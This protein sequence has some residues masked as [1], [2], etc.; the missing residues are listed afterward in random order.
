MR[1]NVK[2][3]L[4]G[5]AALTAVMAAAQ[6]GSAKESPAEIKI[7]TF[8]G[9]YLAGRV[10]ESDNDLDSAI[11]YYKQALGFDPTDQSLQQSLM[12]AL[13]ARGRFDES[14]PYAEQLKQVPEVER[15]SRLAL[16]VDTMRKGNFK[17]TEEWLKL[18]LES[19]LDRLITKLMSAW[20]KLGD[21]DAAG[22]LKAL[23]DLRGPQWY[24]TFVGYHTAL[25]AEAAGDKQKA[26]KA[27]SETMNDVA[28]GSAAPDAYLRSAEAYT[29]F[30]MRDGR[31]NEALAILDRADQFAANR[32]QLKILRDKINKGEPIAPTV[33]T[34][35]D[36]ASEVLLNLGLALNRGGSEPFVRLYLQ[37]AL[38]LNP[39]NDFALM[40]LAEV[41]EQ[42]EDPQGA[43]NLYKRVPANSPFK[44]V[45]EMQL[46]L[47]LADLDRKD[48]AVSHLQKLLDADRKD[49][50]AYM[51]L[52]GVYGAKQDF[53]SAAKVYDEAVA[54]LP[55]ASRADWNIFY[56]RGIAYERLKEWPKAEPNFRRALQLFPDQPQV[57][58]YLGY[59]WVDMNHNLE[60][61]LDLIRKA[62]D[63]RPSDG[64]IVDSLGWA[65]YRLGRFDEAVTELER[66]V[67]LKPDDPVLNDHLGDAYWR[68][69]RELEATF[70]WNHARDLKPE[71]DVLAG[72]QKKLKEGMPPLDKKA[73]DSKAAV[74]PAAPAPQNKTDA[75]PATE[76]KTEAQPAVAPTPA[77]AAAVAEAVPAAYVVQPGQSIWS[78]A[79]ERLNSG[80]RYREIIDLNPQLRN[81]DRLFPGMQLTLPV[82]K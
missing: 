3:L 18:T 82:K 81:P 39:N 49:M 40:N 73:A 4:A 65:Y 48:E 64:Y 31:K 12:L 17:Q 22:S 36:G 56:Q 77:A 41:D 38:A 62:V 69:G 57:M 33:P 66:A 14:L 15:V 58:N 76:D 52:G 26:E 37:L 78:I 79:V 63:L 28:G 8:S 13:I 23:T 45:A 35:V 6:P 75:Q 59:S 10:A 68:V 67:S 29:G 20:A 74:E 71:P 80:E 72:V 44:R 30:L 60:E 55:L 46:G 42:Q 54:N 5:V 32:L 25:I 21:K 1:R 7:S 70:Q 50:R 9:A 24:R 61:G 2:A 43:I 34:A 51:A 16:A 27:Y 19:D 53:R 47:N 11:A